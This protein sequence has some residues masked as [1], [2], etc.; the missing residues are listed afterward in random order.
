MPKVTV[1]IGINSSTPI[2]RSRTIIRAA[3]VMRL[4]SLWAIDHWLDFYPA[5]IWNEDFSWLAKKAASP[6]EY[7]DWATLLGWAAE[8]V[9]KMQLA[10]GVTDPSRHHPIKLAQQALTL[11]HIAR[12][13]PIL[14]IGAGEAENIVPYGINFDT[15]VA[16][17]EEALQIIRTCLDSQGPFDFDGEHFQLEGA[18]MDLTAPPGRTPE[19]WV[20]S[21]QP[22]MLRLTGRYGDGWYPAIT[23]ATDRYAA[24]LATIQNA[25]AAAGRDPDV[26]TPGLSMFYAVAGSEAEAEQLLDSQPLRFFALLAPDSFW[27]EQGHSHPLGQGF[28]GLVDFIPQRYEGPEILEAMAAVPT[29]VLTKHVAWGTPSQ[30]V[31]RLDALAHAGLRHVT[32]VPVSAMVSPRLARFAV[33]AVATIS[34]AVHRM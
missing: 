15:P 17:L 32:L 22:R 2:S 25:A 28:R 9:G 3:K 27:Q 26:I 12:R 1:G 33:R 20:G 23:M 6:H 11:A 21:H 4:D 24:N 18:M 29:D 8:R 16:R 7:F 30:I 5:A 34:R 14:G 31:D 13:P 19:I 10:V